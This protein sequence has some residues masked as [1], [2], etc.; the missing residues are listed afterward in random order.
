MN[1][2]PQYR[3][4]ENE[5]LKLHP[6]YLFAYSFSDGFTMHLFGFD[7]LIENS[8]KA[9]LTSK[10]FMLEGKHEVIE[11][12]PNFIENFLFYLDENPF[13]FE[14]Y[15]FNYDIGMTDIGSQQIFINWNDKSYYFFIEGTGTFFLDNDTSEW[16][17]KLFKLQ[18]KL[19][20]IALQ[21]RKLLISKGNK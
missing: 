10:G 12:T 21:E 7:L 5:Q 16:K 4:I 2:L 8:G 14:N 18:K 1:N 13:P 9:H 15:S 11:K 19:L 3:I 6:D 20:K 17:T